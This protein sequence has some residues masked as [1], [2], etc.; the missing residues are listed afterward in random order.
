MKQFEEVKD[1]LDLQSVVDNSDSRVFQLERVAFEWGNSLSR[2]DNWNGITIGLLNPRFK[3]IEIDAM[4]IRIVSNRTNKGRR[5]LMNI[6]DRSC[7]PTCLGGA[8]Q[9]QLTKK[10]S[11]AKLNLIL[12]GQNGGKR[13]TNGTNSQKYRKN[14]YRPYGLNFQS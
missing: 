6:E 14:L 10:T 1:E 3:D 9:V 2:K 5:I 12:S 11:G 13:R 8:C 7:Y 4:K